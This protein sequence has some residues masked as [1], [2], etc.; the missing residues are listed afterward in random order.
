MK[1]A[2]PNRLFVRLITMTI[3]I[4]M[5]A[6]CDRQGRH[7]MLTVFFTGVP[8]LEA[9]NRAEAEKDDTPQGQQETKQTDPK[10]SVYTHPLAAARLCNQCHVTT[11]NFGMFGQKAAINFSQKGQ[12]S[13][14]KLVVP[15][16]ALCQKCHMDKSEA[17]ASSEGL[18]LHTPAAKGDC[19]KCHDAHQSDHQYLLL[20][21]PRQI[22]IP[23]HSGPKVME[24]PAHQE[25][26]DCL[27][28][29]NP[30]L[31][32]DRKLLTKDYKEVKQPVSPPSGFPAGPDNLPA[33]G[34]IIK[35]E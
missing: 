26:G 4:A 33:G 21:A 24:L 31:G 27:N 7:K 34:S 1:A 17:K 28:C 29:H 30:H 6:G 16:R 13:P 2:N 3:F 5:V 32:K 18:W 10:A 22:C 15:R 8:P 12:P 9:D 14:G 25:P 23:C 20:E 11:A 19:L 35:T